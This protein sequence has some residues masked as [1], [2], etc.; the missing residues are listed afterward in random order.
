MSAFCVCSRFSASSHTTLCGP[1][2]TAT[3]TP[4]FA[5]VG[6]QAVHE[7]RMGRGKP[8]QPGVDLVG[9]EPALTFF[10]LGLESHAGP[11]VSGNQVC[12]AHCILRLRKACQVSISVAQPAF[13]LELE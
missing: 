10:G 4:V 6:R 2:I 3:S 13:G 8:H 12:S 5:A 11:H 9:S 1:S 7:Q